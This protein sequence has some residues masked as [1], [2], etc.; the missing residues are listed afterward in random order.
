[1]HGKEEKTKPKPKAGKALSK[2]RPG[3]V[4]PV[5]GK[6]APVGRG[7]KTRSGGLAEPKDAAAKKRE[8]AAAPAIEAEVIENPE[9]DE[10]LADRVPEL[11]A[12][13]IEAPAE[14]KKALVYT[15]PLQ[16]Y[17]SEIRRTPLLTR[18]EEHDLA[19]RLRKRND[20]E[21]AYQLITANLRLVVKISLEFQRTFI[22]IMDL[23][24]EGNIGLMQAVAKFDPYRGVKL[25]SYASWWIKAY[26]LR[27]ILNNWRMVKIG[28]TQAQRKLFYNLAK[29]K[30]RLE[31]M[32]F[33][34]QANLLAERLDVTTQEVI[35]MDQR[36]SKKEISMDMPLSEDS[37]STVQDMI[38]STDTLP[39][40][41]LDRAERKRL[42]HH[43]LEEF[44]ENLSGKDLLIFR[45]R[46][47]AE[48]PLTL[49]E[50]GEEFGITRE[51][52]R[53]LEG[54]LMDRLKKFLEEKGI[55][56]E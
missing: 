30:E 21:A 34:P 36:L 25:S 13:E 40:I 48:R 42:V 43:T 16:R 27:Y 56:E 38:P 12:G 35:D 17:L 8:K 14:D 15:S 23:I 31:Q 26:I 53:Q 29:E 7:G 11:L 50:L 39:D 54:R 45:H 10:D 20:P 24:Q 28:T 9:A 19:V 44:A 3:P 5:K 37:G 18:E 47:I 52:V 46:M 51:R 6:P 2:S 4:S 49:Q 41:Q 1:M 22:N 55:E 33:A 32:G